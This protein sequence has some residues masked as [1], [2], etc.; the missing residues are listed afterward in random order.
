MRKSG[1]VHCRQVFLTVYAVR[2]GKRF[3]IKIHVVVQ[4]VHFRNVEIAI[5]RALRIR[6]IPRRHYCRRC[7]ALMEFRIPRCHAAVTVIGGKR[8]RIVKILHNRRAR[9][10]RYGDFYR[11]RLFERRDRELHCARKRHELL[12]CIRAIRLARQQ[13]R[14]SAR[15]IF[16]KHI[17]GNLPAH[18]VA[19][20]RFD[21][22]IFFQH[23][24]RRIGRHVPAHFRRDTRYFGEIRRFFRRDAVKIHAVCESRLRFGT[25]AKTPRIALVVEI[26]RK[27]VRFLVVRFLRCL[28]GDPSIPLHFALHADVPICK[29]RMREGRI[30]HFGKIFLTVFFIRRGKRTRIEINVIIQRIDLGN[31][32][33]RIDNTLRIGVRF[34]RQCNGTARAADAPCFAPI[35]RTAVAV[36]G[37]KCV[38]IVKIL[39]NRRVRCR[40]Y[41]DFYRSRLFKRRN[42]EFHCTRK[43]HI[44]LAL[45]RTTRFARQ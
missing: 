42:R 45:V 40:C 16:C 5:D 9:C 7:A 44:I 33:Q 30:D 11:S 38:F 26:D 37:R 15:Y 27:R 29:P 23:A 4:G 28:Y 35:R 6:L 19:I 12:T 13:R 17:I 25:S 39:H 21:C 1:C 34:R 20:R 10:R 14:T 8:V 32:D 3:R 43:R 18:A 36:I 41:G 31:I 2:V 24:Y 22:K